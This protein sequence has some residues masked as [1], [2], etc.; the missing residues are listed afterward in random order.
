[1]IFLFSLLLIPMDET[2]TD[3][4]RAY[5]VTYHVLKE[6]FEAEWL[7][8]Y[9][10]GSFLLPDLPDIRKL[11]E[12]MG[13]RYEVLSQDEVNDIYALMERENMERVVLEKAPRIA[14]YIP[15]REGPWDDAVC[16]AMEYAGIPYDRIYD[17]DILRGKL[18]KYDWIHL[19]HEDFTGQFG[20]FYRSYRH[21]RWYKE[22]VASDTKIARKF[23]FSKVWQLKHRVA[24]EIRRYVLEGGHLFAMCSAPITLDIALATGD[25]D[26]VPPEIDGDG[27]NEN[28]VLDFSRTFAFK[29]FHLVFPIGIYEH[30]DV[31]VTMEA[32][33]R[34]PGARF[35]L[36]EFSAKRDV[37]PTILVQNHTR[38][39]KEF[40]GQ[41]TGFR[42][43]KIKGDVIILAD[44]PG[45][46]EVKY[47]C[48]ERGKGTF[49]FLGGHD[50]EDYQHFVGD[51]PTRLELHKNSPGYRL[52]LNNILL[53][54]AR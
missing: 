20:K 2:Q 29:D 25:Q 4:L 51:P 42:R 35:V 53:P 22:M 18:K 43:D 30:S 32:V 13:V 10:G 3:H 5:G 27:Y 50:P 19:H 14:V 12:R 8:N 16:L 11:C 6:G 45:T 21:T 28:P 34:G 37:L 23:G 31:D 46:E 40:L 24:E 52:I 41:D 39:I 44:I 1:M 36:R 48:G 15:E 38:R 26:I 47:I 7:L 33:H 49:S 54:A 17:E 9:R